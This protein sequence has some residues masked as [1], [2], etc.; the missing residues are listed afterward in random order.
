MSWDV[1]IM[2]FSRPY[3]AISEI[4]DDERPLSLGSRAYVHEL[5]LREFPHTNWTDPAWGVW[6]GASGSIEFNLGESDPA[7]GLMLHVRAGRDVVASIV[8]LCLSNQWQ[9]IDCSTG[10]FIEQSLEPTQGLDSWAS[11]RDHVVG[12]GEA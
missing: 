7:D 8:R 4:P 6:D 9:G 11:H 3:R 12:S 5:V 2:K 10:E 1:S